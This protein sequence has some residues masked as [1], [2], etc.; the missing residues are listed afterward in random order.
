MVLIVGPWT[1]EVGELSGWDAE[2]FQEIADRDGA[3]WVDEPIEYPP[4]SV[5]I[6]DALAADDVVGTNRRLILISAVVEFLGVALVCKRV[7][8][9]TAKS[10]L[11]FGTP[12]VPMGYMRLDMM[13]TVIAFAAAVALL[14][15]DDGEPRHRAR[16]RAQHSKPRTQQQSALGLLPAVSFGLLVGAGAMIKLW[17]A[18]LIAG[19]FAIGRRTAAFWAA[20]ATGVFG[21]V[22]LALV[23]AGLDPV[24]QVLS[25][26]GATGWHLE[27]LPGALIAAFGDEQPRLELNA[28]RIGTLNQTVVSIGRVMALAMMAALTVVAARAGDVSRVRRLGLVMLGATAALLATAPLLSP[29]FV[30]W[31]TPWGALLVGPGVRSRG[32]QPTIWLLGVCLLLTGIPL[33]VFGPDGLAAT[34]PALLLTARNAALLA[35]PLVCLLQL[36]AAAGQPQTSW[37]A[38]GKTR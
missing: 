28:F 21:V 33:V 25:L 36:R 5:V 18:L 37:K 14:A 9:T 1:D 8:A 7:G 19:A 31:L 10:F 34:G 16:E 12:L 6:F 35:L 24:D 23:G 11:V 15:G 27:S 2:R 22:W 38:E 29:Q 20:A 3:A 4:G 32:D 17:P 30:L 13:V 26:R